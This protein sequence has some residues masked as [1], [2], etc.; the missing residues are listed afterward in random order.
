[1]S[2]ALDE[3]QTQGETSS[4]GRLRVEIPNCAMSAPRTRNQHRGEDPEL[5]NQGSNQRLRGRIFE[6]RQQGRK[7]RRERI[8]GDVAHE[9]HGG[10]EDGAT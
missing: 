8:D 4:S 2:A 10:Q 3:L 5:G 9:S 1:M 7:S 6:R